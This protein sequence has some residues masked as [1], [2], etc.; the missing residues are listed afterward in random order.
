MAQQAAAAAGTQQD[1]RR[2]ADQ[3]AGGVTEVA[4]GCCCPSGRVQ[5][6]VMGWLEGSWGDR[7]SAFKQQQQTSAPGSGKTCALV[8][9]MALPASLVVSNHTKKLFGSILARPRKQSNAKQSPWPDSVCPAPWTAE[10]HWNS[11]AVVT[12]GPRLLCV[13]AWRAQLAHQHRSSSESCSLRR[14]LPASRQTRRCVWGATWRVLG[15]HP[16]PG[17]AA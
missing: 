3:T 15:M 8:A 14:L 7:S 13:V 16:A 5:I 17:A 12:A 11:A 4:G 6:V 2:V 10:N 1:P 9:C